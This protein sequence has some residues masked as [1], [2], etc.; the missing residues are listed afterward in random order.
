M[1]KRAFGQQNEGIAVDY[2]K[3]KGYVV[4]HT[5]WHCPYGELDIIAR[6]GDTLVFVEVRSRHSASTDNAFESIGARKRGRVI[7]AA[8]YYVSRHKLHDALWRIDLLAVAIPPTGA[9]LIDHV[10]NA[11]DW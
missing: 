4:L 9:P 3:R 11:L 2:L 5:N 8:Q 7:R 6:D 10:E 1:Q